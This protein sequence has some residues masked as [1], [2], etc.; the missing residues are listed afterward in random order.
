MADLETMRHSAAH[1]M[2]AAVQRLFPGTRLGVGPAIENGF[3]YDLDVP[4]RLT[5]EDLAAIEAEMA[6][7]VAAARALRARGAAARRRDRALPG[8]ARSNTR[9]SC[10][11]TCASAAPRASAPLAAKR[12]TSTPRIAARRRS[13][14]LA[15]TS[16]CVWDRTWPTAVRSDRSSCSPSRVPTGAG[17]ST[18]P[19]SSASTA[20]SGPP[21]RSWSNTSG[22]IEEARRR[23]HRRLGRDLRLFFFDE[24]A[25]GQPFMLPRGMAV[26]R[27]AGGALAARARQ[28]RL[29]G[30]QY[31]ELVKSDLWEQ[32][33]HWGYYRRTCSSARSRTSSTPSS[34]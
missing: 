8:S 20:R 11:A 5:T 16:I 19:S 7:I 21:P 15:T 28:P 22:S 9:S 13:T 24:V 30:D 31:A 34:R 2:A 10:C 6:S 18:A 27:V 26:V 23:D 25:P 33:G 4:Q 14:G 3:Y 12:S 17:T 1:V 29:P 32:S